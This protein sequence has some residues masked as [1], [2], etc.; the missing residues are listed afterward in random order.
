MHPNIGASASSGRHCVR[1][2]LTGPKPMYMYPVGYSKPP[3]GRIRRTDK[4][5]R[6]RRPHPRQHACI[7]HAPHRRF[8]EALVQIAEHPAHAV[9]RRIDEHGLELDF[10]RARPCQSI[11]DLVAEPRRRKWTDCPEGPV[12]DTTSENL[13]QRFA[14]ERLAGHLRQI[15]RQRVLNTCLCELHLPSPPQSGQHAALG[16]TDQP[17]Q[18]APCSC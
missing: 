3:S 4:Q 2:R 13:L 8:I 5:A 11:V 6:T 14:M 15:D 9:Q 7:F 17:W 16:A 12:G 18:T 10:V 1:H